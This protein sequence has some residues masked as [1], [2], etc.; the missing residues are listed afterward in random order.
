MLVAAG[1]FRHEV[2]ERLEHQAI[3]QKL[4]DPGTEEGE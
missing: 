3:L 4:V 2:F 1:Q